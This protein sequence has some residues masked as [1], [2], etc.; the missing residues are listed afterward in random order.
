ML[1]FRNE[2]VISKTDMKSA[3]IEL[4]IRLNILKLS[5]EWLSGLSSTSNLML[6]IIQDLNIYD[7]KNSPGFYPSVASRI[8]ELTMSIREKGLLHPITVRT[9]ERHFEIV[10]GNR[11]FLA[12]KS[13]GW[14]K[15]LCHVV[16]LDDRE[17]FE[18]SLVE[19][20]QRRTL[21]PIE[22]GHAFRTYVSQFGWGGISDL[23]AKIGK[24]VSYVDRRLRLLGL[25]EE[26]LEKVTA[27]L[28]AVSVAEE[29]IP[30]RDENRQSELADLISKR[31]MS[32]KE[33][34][35][36]IN[37]SEDSIYNS[38]DLPKPSSAT[39]DVSDLD[40]RTQRCLDK[41]IV[42]IRIAMNKLAD[43]M[44]SVEDNW[45]MY[46][47]LMQHKN[48]LHGQIDLLIKEKKKI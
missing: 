20:I 29:L 24:S 32:T 19:N 42:A 33:A 10:A 6:G 45:I 44:E 13:L 41:S 14:R 18:I 22:E 25:P 17:A 3:Y 48:V 30:V 21:N 34:R 38:Q 4:S 15:I 12:C 23:A 7:L 43:I 47:T 28:L 40:R 2:S 5:K 26:I 16:E 31:R 35:K 1:I 46:E 8:N 36:L 39:E 27:S 11:R 37:C 9:K